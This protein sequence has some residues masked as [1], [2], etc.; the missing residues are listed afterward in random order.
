LSLLLLSYRR[1]Q[2]CP[3]VIVVPLS[4]PVVVV[5]L[6]S[7]PIVVVVLSSFAIVIVV[8]SSSSSELSHHCSSGCH[9]PVSTPIS[10]CE[11]WLA[12]WVV[13]LCWGRGQQL[14]VV[15]TKRKNLKEEKEKVS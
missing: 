14:D 15:I 8:L 12:G 3:I 4:F 11:Q 13:V 10:P 1:R 7:F 2:C 6:S 5:V 9:S